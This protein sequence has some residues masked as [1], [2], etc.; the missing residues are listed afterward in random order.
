MCMINGKLLQI[1]P[2][3]IGPRETHLASRPCNMVLTGL[4]PSWFS[5]TV[6]LELAGGLLLLLGFHSCSKNSMML[7]CIT[8]TD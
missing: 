5:Q 8:D 4:T 3:Q 6:G 2:H 7:L 1:G